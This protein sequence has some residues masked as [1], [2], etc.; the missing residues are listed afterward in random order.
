MFF[1][2]CYVLINANTWYTYSQYKR[3]YTGQGDAMIFLPSVIVMINGGLVW[4]IY[5]HRSANR[6]WIK[7]EPTHICTTPCWL[8]APCFMLLYLV[9]FLALVYECLFCGA[10]RLAVPMF[11]T[12]TCFI[13]IVA[14]MLYSVYKEYQW[15]KFVFYY[16]RWCCEMDFDDRFDY[17]MAY[18]KRRYFLNINMKGIEDVIYAYFSH[19]KYKL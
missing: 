7:E 10:Y 5:Q 19:I 12:G 2:G 13:F 11:I 6:K 17:I 1:L 3:E 16:H 9:G 4:A 8:I 18:W 14:Y 15:A